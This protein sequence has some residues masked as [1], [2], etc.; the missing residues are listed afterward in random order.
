MSLTSCYFIWTTVGAILP[1]NQNVSGGGLPT[2]YTADQF[3]FHW[4]EEDDK[5]SEHTI[6]TISYPLEV[7]STGERRMIRDLNIP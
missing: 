6:D 2:S 4:G 3:H 5:G 1:V 7:S